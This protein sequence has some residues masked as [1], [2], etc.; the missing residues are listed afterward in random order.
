MKD[1]LNLSDIIDSKLQSKINI[2][3]IFNHLRKNG[4]ASRADIARALNISRP[5]VSRVIEILIRH[6]YV[7]ET[8]K[9]KTSSGKR[10]TILKI[11]QNKGYVIGID[12]G[13]EKL[14]IAI[15]DFKGEMIEKFKGFKI[16]NS[17]D[18]ASKVIDE[19]RPILMKNNKKEELYSPKIKAI[20]IG[21]PANIDINTGKV[22]SALVYNNWKN[23]NFK[24]II[25][26]EFNIPVYI[27]ND[28]NL[29]ALAEMYYGEGKKFKN[30]IFVEISN[31]IGAGIIIDNRLFRGSYGSAGEI[32]FTI[33]N[34]GNLG[35]EIKNKGFL[36]KFASVE[37]IKKRAI[38]EIKN[39]KKTIITKMVK[40]DIEKIDPILVCE[41]A[42]RGDELAKNII[43]EMVDFLSISIINLILI[44]NPQIII[45]GG[46]ICNLPEVNKLF[47]DPIIENVMSSVPLTIPEIKL[48][49]LGGDA[50]VIGASFFA[51]ESLIMSE[52]PYKIHEGAIS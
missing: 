35:Y 21:V 7:I 24:E 26:S 3:I 25:R 22:I 17:K 31:G 29:S 14:G 50:G 19:I 45:L 34:S 27:E 9:K 13:K 8:E 1:P 52:F 15:T 33:I 46:D 43:N 47:V 12:L 30:I 38:R 49:S 4:T 41:A 6:N 51:T 40:D 42:I 20:C 16:S 36:E 48:S 5:T 11:N 44:Q 37:S 39:K 32:A 10:P 23:L 2:S 18:I 28:V